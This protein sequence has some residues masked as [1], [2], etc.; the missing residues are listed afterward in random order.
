MPLRDLQ[1]GRIRT[2]RDHQPVDHTRAAG[3][4]QVCL[5]GEEVVLIPVKSRAARK[6][7]SK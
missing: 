2:G 1:G 7:P 6:R 3:P 5:P 4:A